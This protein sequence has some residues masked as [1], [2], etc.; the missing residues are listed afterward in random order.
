MDP[1]RCLEF[2]FPVKQNANRKMSSGDG[3]RVFSK[4]IL[5]HNKTIKITF[6]IYERIDKNIS[7][8]ALNAR[9]VT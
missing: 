5:F 9:K 6:F 7:A 4:I 1:I 2:A 8:V 3:G